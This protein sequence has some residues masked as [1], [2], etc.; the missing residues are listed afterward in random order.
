M[1]ERFFLPN[2]RTVRYTAGM[3]VSLLAGLLFSLCCSSALSGT[4]ISKTSYHGWPEAFILSNGLVEAV[5][6]PA[7]GRIMQLRFQGEETGPFWENRLLDGK[8]PQPESSEWINFGGD[9]VW[10]APQG[11]WAKIAGRAWPPPVGFDASRRT[12]ADENGSLVMR[13]PVDSR[14]GI[15]VERIL[16]LA[17]NSAELTV[18]TKFQK[19]TGPPVR[20]SMWTVSQLGHPERVYMPLPEGSAGYKKQSDKLPT[21]LVATNGLVV[22]ERSPAFAAK[23]GAD[24]SRLVWAGNDQI[25]EVFTRREA[26]EE[27][28]DEGSSA[29]IYTNPDPNAYVELELLGPL[30]TLGQGD[31][32]SRVQRYR[33]FRRTPAPLESQL[34]AAGLLQP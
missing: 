22:C 10:P 18:T 25:L 28:P 16:T 33:L 23:V 9:K 7:I 29:E 13:S 26:G 11:E 17:T 32:L 24:A 21:G 8:S 27:F 4:V 30:R 5:V 19:R 15:Q 14:Y 1:P 34:R 6:V 12:I 3:R 2:A 31:E 20:V